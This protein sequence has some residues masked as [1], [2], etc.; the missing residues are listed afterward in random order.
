MVTRAS[1]PEDLRD[2]IEEVVEGGVKII[3]L[4]KISLLPKTFDDGR[5]VRDNL[6]DGGF[7]DAAHTYEGDVRVSEESG[8]HILDEAIPPEEQLRWNG[9][10]FW[11]GDVVYPG[12]IV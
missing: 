4:D 10:E 5:V 12:T 9:G 6:G 7:P 2:A 3:A 11:S 8:D 1:C